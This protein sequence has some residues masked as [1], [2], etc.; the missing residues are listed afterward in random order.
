[1]YKTASP[2]VIGQGFEV[3]AMATLALFSI[4]TI[5]FECF[6]SDYSI[7]SCDLVAEDFG[8]R[9]FFADDYCRACCCSNVFKQFTTVAVQLWQCFP[10]SRSGLNTSLL[11]TKREAVVWLL[12]DLDHKSSGDEYCC[13][14]CCCCSSFKLDTTKTVKHWQ[15]SQHFSLKQSVLVTS[16]RITKFKAVV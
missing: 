15:H 13:A 7:K 6:S 4:Q 8:S 10:S 14:C 16:F 5:R 3:S 1:M 11:M 12:E 2:A 9:E